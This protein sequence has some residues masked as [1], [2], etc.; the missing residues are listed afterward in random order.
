M[1]KSIS[2][3][4]MRLMFAGAV[5]VFG[6][7]CQAGSTQFASPFGYR[8][9][10]TPS[11][12][13]ASPAFAQVAAGQ[14][15]PVGA[16]AQRP[17]MMQGYQPQGM[18]AGGPPIVGSGG[19]VYPVGY[20]PST[21]QPQMP[22]MAGH[23][24][25]MNHAMQPMQQPMMQQTMQQPTMQ[26][27]QMHPQMMGSMPV[28]PHMAGML[29]VQSQSPAPSQ[30][31]VTVVQGPNGP[32]YVYTEVVSSPTAPHGAGLP[33]APAGNTTTFEVPLPNTIPAPALPAS[34]TVPSPSFAPSESTSVRPPEMLPPLDPI[35]KAPTNG[36]MLPA[37]VPVHSPALGTFPATPASN[38]TIPVG[39][40]LPA[41]KPAT[42][43]DIPPAP[44]F[45]PSG[46]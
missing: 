35:G 22:M 2:R 23:Q 15:L 18:I 39:A 31:Q 37:T 30:P 1:L 7:G 14:H 26:Q 27:G 3:R 13:P 41:P 28:H 16:M 8:D 6:A 40:K 43:D 19:M 24:P 34:A 10:M 5:A 11:T 25:M 12:V 38:A 9:T 33:T 36:A 42:D 32:Q 17:G 45:I 21:S 4:P 44:V 20:L 46:K 29:P